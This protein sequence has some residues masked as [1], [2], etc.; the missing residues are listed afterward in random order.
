MGNGLAQKL[1]SYTP[2]SDQGLDCD[3]P[4]PASCTYSPVLYSAVTGPL[5]RRSIPVSP[6]WLDPVVRVDHPHARAH[7]PLMRLPSRLMPADSQYFQRSASLPSPPLSSILTK[8]T[9]RCLPHAASLLTDN[10]KPDV[11]PIKVPDTH[12]IPIVGASESQSRL[13]AGPDISRS[14]HL[15]QSLPHGHQ[16]RSLKPSLRKCELV[17]TAYG[18]SLNNTKPELGSLS[19]K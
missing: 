2:L 1:P 12:T 16:M 8:H 6:V 18:T 14:V 3:I 17:G 4:K 9:D 10:L 13:A 5:A 19:V 11:Q 15:R 7:N